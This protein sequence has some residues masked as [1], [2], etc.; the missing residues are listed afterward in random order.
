[1]SMT[2]SGG[3]WLKVDRELDRAKGG[4]GGEGGL[5]WSPGINQKWSGALVMAIYPLA[6]MKIK[7]LFG[8]RAGTPPSR[9]LDKKGAHQKMNDAYIK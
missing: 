3:L 5:S 1:M 2:G 6:Q 7:I 4:E 8:L 9:G